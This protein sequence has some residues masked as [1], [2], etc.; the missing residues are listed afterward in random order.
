MS[1]IISLG[2]KY[3][4]ADTARYYSILVSQSQLFF[5]VAS[6]VGLVI[7]IW[8]MPLRSK[9]KMILIGMMSSTVVVLAYFFPYATLLLISY[10]LV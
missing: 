3:D 7:G 6:W 9:D 4:T 1:T 2:C 8:T 5:M 10:L